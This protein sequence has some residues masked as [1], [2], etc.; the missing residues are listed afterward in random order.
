LNCRQ[1]VSPCEHG[2]EL[3]PSSLVPEPNRCALGKTGED[4]ACAELCRRGYAILDR[5]FRTRDGEIDIVARDGAVLV[6]VEVKTRR[7][8]RFGLPR[9][10]VTLRKQHRMARMAAAYLARRHPRAWS[11]RFD[12]VEITLDRDGAPRIEVLRSAFDGSRAGPGPR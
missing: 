6:F 7:S 12:V 4:L 1:P 10:A 8:L 11:C 9:A 3:A 2:R 5:R